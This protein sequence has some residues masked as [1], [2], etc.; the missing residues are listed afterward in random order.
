MT[1]K[2]TTLSPKTKAATRTTV[3]RVTVSSAKT[4]APKVSSSTVLDHTFSNGVKVTGT[5]EQLET[6]AKAMGMKLEGI[7]DLK[8]YYP[9]ESKG[10]VKISEMNDYHIR[11]ALLKRSKDY[12]TEIYDKDDTNSE[13]LKKF[14]SLANDQIIVDLFNE[15]YKRK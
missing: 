9:S 4:I 8:G 13:F 12:F 11:R 15:L 2:K 10:L 5:I 14:T 7:K 1:T 6:I 3:S